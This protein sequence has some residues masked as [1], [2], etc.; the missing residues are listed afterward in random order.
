MFC[1]VRHVA[2]PATKTRIL[3]LVVLRVTLKSDKR[4]LT[5]T[6]VRTICEETVEIQLWSL[7]MKQ[8]RKKAVERC[9]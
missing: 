8:R 7:Y 9:G 4:S 5:G 1:S 6:N 2:T 3:Y